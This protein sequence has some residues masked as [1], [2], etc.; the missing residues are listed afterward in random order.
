M[1][2]VARGSRNMRIGENAQ[3]PE[4]TP[5]RFVSLSNQAFET[6]GV[7]FIQGHDFN[8]EDAQKPVCILNREAERLAGL[9]SGKATGR[10]LTGFAK[11]PLEVIGVV[12]DF[13]LFQ[14]GGS[15][16][17]VVFQPL[18]IFPPDALY[19]RSALSKT[20]LEATISSVMR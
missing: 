15:A 17:P 14:D 13:H 12:P 16:M 7:S 11:T 20:D 18:N 5:M 2:W 19:V 10:A 4:R 1:S 3:F 9:S 8:A 6:L